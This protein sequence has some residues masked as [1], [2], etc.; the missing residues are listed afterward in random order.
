MHAP[1]ATETHYFPLANLPNRRILLHTHFDA[2]F[3]HKTSHPSSSV[4]FSIY[5]SGESGC[6]QE[7][8]GFDIS[9]DWYATLGR[10]PSRYLHTLISWAAGIVSIIVFIA[11]GQQEQGGAPRE[12]SV[13]RECTD[14][15][16][17]THA[18]NTRVSRR[19]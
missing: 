18:N 14:R 2:P 8:S 12:N 13:G 17:S 9:F 10:W 1:H 4:N 6:Q 16:Y 7:F 11:W 3:I 5:S 15:E 19:L